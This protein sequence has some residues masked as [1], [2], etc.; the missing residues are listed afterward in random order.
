M[1]VRACLSIGISRPGSSI[2]K[3]GLHWTK[4]MRG[5]AGR[6]CSRHCALTRSCRILPWSWPEAFQ[7]ARQKIYCNTACPMLRAT[8]GCFTSWGDA[9][10]FPGRGKGQLRFS[11]GPLQTTG[12]IPRFGHP[13]CVGWIRP[14]SR[15]AHWVWRIVQGT[16]RP[17]GFECTSI[18]YGRSRR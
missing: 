4:A 3:H 1:A 16:V 17:W 12:T 5:C 18:I 8:G 9:P 7:S 13:L 14:Q 6:R 2:V 11:P 10:L 15:N